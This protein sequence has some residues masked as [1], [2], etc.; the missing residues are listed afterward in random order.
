M[1]CLKDCPVLTGFTETII[2]LRADIERSEGALQQNEVAR[3]QNQATA[4]QLATLP[5]R[6]EVAEARGLL[7]EAIVQVGEARAQLSEAINLSYDAIE[8]N[9]TAS[10]AVRSNCSGEPFYIDDPTQ[11]G[12]MILACA[13]PGFSE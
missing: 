10:G 13:S 5:P 1:E 6:P 12:N 2:G 7:Q 8:A 11:P 3:G 9:M 4:R